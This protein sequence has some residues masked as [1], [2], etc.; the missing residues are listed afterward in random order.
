MT[1]TLFVLLDGTED[2]PNPEL[3]GKKPFD[4]ADMPFIKSNVQTRGF[5]TGRD[6]THIF[7]NELFTGHQP[8]LQRAVLEAMG[9]GMEVTP[10]RA[11]FRLSPAR[12]SDGMIRWA[13][14]TD[15]FR[16]KLQAAV[17]KHLPL[18]SHLNPQFRFF[19]SSRAIVT[20]DCDDIPELPGPPKDTEYVE[21]PGAM[22]ELVRAVANDLDGLTDYPWGVGTCDEQYPHFE[23]LDNLMA[24]SDSPTSLG[25]CASLG[26]GF[27]VIDD[28]EE[29]FA[30]AAEALE[31]GNVFLH[32][33]EI[34]EYSH[35]KKWK[36]KVEI[37]ETADRLMSKYF[38][39]HP[40]IFYFV[41]HGTS[42]VT[43]EHLPITVPFWSNYGT[44]I[45]DGEMVPLNTLVNRMMR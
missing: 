35:M 27:K 37:L 15:S 14:D 6:Y 38:S 11:A 29:R 41:D 19:I 10:G 33:D 2:D 12:I 28:L 24:F 34:D 31:H 21:V 13:Y 32:I 17:T 26:Y 36:K 42:C 8:K 30:T 39:G 1:N 5:T 45:E 16:E 44:D 9:F 40:R 25:I 4:V 43:G 20:V 23:C 7:L 18:I 3:G 22:G